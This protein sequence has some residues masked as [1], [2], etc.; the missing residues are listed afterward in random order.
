MI[1]HVLAFLTGASF[2]GFTVAGSLAYAAARRQ[3]QE[4]KS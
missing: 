4:R 3:Q 1:D 2:G